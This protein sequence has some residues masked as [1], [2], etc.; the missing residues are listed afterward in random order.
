MYRQSVTGPVYTIERLH[1]EVAELSPQVAE[2]IT[3]VCRN[4]RLRFVY[5]M[6]ETLEDTKIFHRIE[7]TLDDVLS[8][9]CDHLGLIPFDPGV[10]RSLREPG[11]FSLQFPGSKTASAFDRLAGRVVRYWPGPLEDSAELLANYARELFPETDV[12]GNIKAS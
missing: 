6:A 11:I 9:G 12:E 8:L 3:D 10:R 1:D 7:Q 5:N 2:K 4:I